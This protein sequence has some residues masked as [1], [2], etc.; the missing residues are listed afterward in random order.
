MLSPR[1]IAEHADDFDVF[2]VHFGF[3]ALS[4][5]ELGEVVQELRRAGK[6]LVYT[7]HDLRNP[8]HEDPSAHDAHLDVLMP[9]AAS[10]VTLTPG[11]AEVIARRWGRHAQVLPH[12]H[13]VEPDRM[14][15][16]RPTHEGFVIGVH[17][18]SVRPS[19]APVPVLTELLPLVD[20]LPG[21]RLVVDV[22]HDV[23]DEGGARHDVALRKFLVEHASAGRLELS[24]HDCFSDDE[25]WDYLQGLDVSVLPYRFGTHS[26]WLEACYDLGT[27]VV[28][29]DCGFLFEQRPCSVYHHDL[30]GLDG[31]SLRDAVRRIFHE[32]PLWRASVADRIVERNAIARAHYELYRAARR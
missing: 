32:R 10:L 30:T 24:V 27:P 13:V 19:M 4:A 15:P 14:R 12:P 21:A 5:E 16:D 29:P 17:A 18:K 6:P 20:E 7:V 23:F 26:G 1:W 25:L 31:P 8:H 22:H 28:V 9:N 3:D 2:H 11:A